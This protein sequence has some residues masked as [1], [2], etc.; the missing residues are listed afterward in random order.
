MLLAGIH[1]ALD[2]LGA[3][4]GAAVA[5]RSLRWATLI[6]ALILAVVVGRFLLATRPALEVRLFPWAFYPCVEPWW[7]YPFVFF[8]LGAALTAARKS[9]WKRDLLMV[10]AGLLLLR[11]GDMT[12][13]EVRPRPELAGT[14]GESGFCRQTSAYSCGAA[15]AAMFLHLY[16]I[17]ATEDEMA[18]LCLTRSGTLGGTTHAG[19]ALGLRRKGLE[20]RVRAPERITGP[21]IVPIRQTW[22]VS[23]FVVVRKVERDRV[24]V[25]DPTHGTYS[26]SR[27]R[28][29]TLWEGSVVECVPGRA[30]SR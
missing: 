9:V 10:F 13:A 14:V 19:L 16:G 5:R 22:L 29:S 27:E 30:K 6:S 2:A 24:Y 4:A 21:A 17:T 23:H 25:S 20:V 1:L 26:M 18:R 12:W 8:L 11:L 7:F 3:A 28:F 15:S